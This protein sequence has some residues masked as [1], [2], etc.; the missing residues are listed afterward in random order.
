MSLRCA[1]DDPRRVVDRDGDKSRRGLD[2]RDHEYVLIGFAVGEAG[3]REQGDDRAIVRQRVHA[4]RRER[5]DAMHD[6]ERNRVRLGRGDKAIGKSAERE[7][8]AARCRAGDPAQDIGGDSG[9]EQRILDRR[10]GRR[11][12][13]K[14]GQR[15]DDRAGSH[16]RRPC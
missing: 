12:L 16:I 7:A 2:Q 8:E 13:A 10:K 4:A 15:R 11:D 6:L 9:V 14:A 3:N 1:S 5:C